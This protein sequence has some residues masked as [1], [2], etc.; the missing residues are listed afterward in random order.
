M[1]LPSEAWEGDWAL[2]YHVL[3]Q[4][5]ETLPWITLGQEIE[6]ARD[7][8]GRLLT[9]RSLPREV[10]RQR[11]LEEAAKL[12]KMLQEYAFSVPIRSLERGR[13]PR[14]V[15]EQQFDTAWPL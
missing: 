11:Y 10:A 3:R 9:A 12:D 1:P 6:A 2:A 8:L 4:A 14:H 7:R 15:A 5:G 13:L